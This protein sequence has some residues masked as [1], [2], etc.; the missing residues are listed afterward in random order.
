MVWC[1]K[2]IYSIVWVRNPKLL[3]V[4]NIIISFERDVGGCWLL[5]GHCSTYALSFTSARV[6]G[7][8]FKRMYM[9]WMVIWFS[10]YKSSMFEDMDSTFSKETLCFIASSV[11]VLWRL[12]VHS[13]SSLLEYIPTVDLLWLIWVFFVRNERHFHPKQSNISLIWFK[14]LNWMLLFFLLKVI[15][16][17]DYVLLFD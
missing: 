13:G 9:F 11:L 15:L 4:D 6:M 10:M 8:I 12:V 14:V 5:L 7:Y 3:P 2:K 17:S 1:Y 16:D